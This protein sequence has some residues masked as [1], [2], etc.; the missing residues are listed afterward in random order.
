MC[1]PACSARNWTAGEVVWYGRGVV[2]DTMEDVAELKGVLEGL[3]KA[4]EHGIANIDLYLKSDILGQVCLRRI[5]VACGSLCS[6]RA[7]VYHMQVIAERHQGPVIRQQR[8]HVYMLRL[9][10]R[11]ADHACPSMLYQIS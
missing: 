4:H 3:E 5:G 11:A 10:C 6:V 7:C 2:K 8:L 1:S 9:Y